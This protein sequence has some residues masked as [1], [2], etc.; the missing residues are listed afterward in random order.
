MG[1]KRARYYDPRISDT[2]KTRAGH[3]Q[4]AF[5]KRMGNDRDRSEWIAEPA[6]NR[7]PDR[8][9]ILGAVAYLTASDDFLHTGCALSW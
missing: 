7:P 9:T 3:A 8:L 1:A 6:S 2:S 4:R 5:L